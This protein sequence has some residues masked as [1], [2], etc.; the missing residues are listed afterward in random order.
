MKPVQDIRTGNVDSILDELLTFFIEDLIEKKEVSE[1][2]WRSVSD[3]RISKKDVDHL[4][5]YKLI[6]TDNESDK[7]RIDFKNSM[8]AKR[9]SVLKTKLM[10]ADYFIDNKKIISEDEK[11]IENSIKILKDVSKMSADK[12]IMIVDLVAIGLWRMMDITGMS[13]ESER[14]FTAGYSPKKWSILSHK[15]IQ[16]LSIELTRKIQKINSFND[17]I[18]RMRKEGFF[19]DNIN[20]T[21]I[22]DSDFSKIKEIIDWDIIMN[23]LDENDVVLL[24]LTWFMVYHLS[25]SNTLPL[26][27]ES[28]MDISDVIKS[29]VEDI[30]G[31]NWDDLIENFKKNIKSLEEKNI[32]WAS[33]FVTLPE[34][35]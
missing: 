33:F 27:T 2:G 28:S 11:R 14:I 13:A 6:E 16:K 22:D 15:S 1:V 10:Q 8:S 23:E 9:N 4:K 17:A 24:G 21:N 12:S 29:T 30:T 31:K 19:L 35:I 7:I 25:V 3:L 5:D 20:I 34:A 32:Y 26:M 18:L